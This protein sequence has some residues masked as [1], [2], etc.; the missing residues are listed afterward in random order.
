MLT[1]PDAI[2][3]KLVRFVSA[4]Q[5]RGEIHADIDPVEAARCLFAI[6]YQ[7]LQTWLGTYVS[8]SIFKKNMHVLLKFVV[9]GMSVDGIHKTEPSR[10]KRTSQNGKK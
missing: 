7:Q 2:I 6:Y 1:I 9:D 10:N 3:E 5:S 4:A 8:H